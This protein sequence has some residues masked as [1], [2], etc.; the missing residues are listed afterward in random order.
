M[1]H[2][3]HLPLKLIATI[4]SNKLNDTFTPLTIEID[5]HNCFEQTDKKKVTIVQLLF[6]LNSFDLA[7]ITTIINYKLWCQDNIEFF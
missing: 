2:L 7:L 4:V 6:P 1:I 5:C 3:L